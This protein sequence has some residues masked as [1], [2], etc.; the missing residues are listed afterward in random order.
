MKKRLVFVPLFF[1]LA[2]C[3]GRKN[4]VYPDNGVLTYLDASAGNVGGKLDSTG[5]QMHYRGP[6][7]DSIEEIQ[8]I[9]ASAAWRQGGRKAA[10]GALQQKAQKLNADGIYDIQFV[11]DSDGTEASGIAFRFRR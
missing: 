1:L 4:R 3:A 6:L 10:L 8:L 9:E 2:A 7:K 11:D 5:V